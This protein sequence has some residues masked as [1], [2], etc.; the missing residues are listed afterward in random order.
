MR[1][2]TRKGLITMAATGGLLALSGGTALADSGAQGSSGHSPGVIS[3]NTF[4]APVNVTVNIC[5]NT[6]SVLGLLNPASGNGCSTGAPAGGSGAQHDRPGQHGGQTGHSPQGGR[7]DQATGG[8][9][10]GS[11]AHADGSSHGSPGV[12]SGNDVQVPVD[13]P[14]NVC[15]NSVDVVGVLNPAHG[16]DCGNPS[17]PAP[18]KPGKP[19]EP[20]KPGNPGEPEKPGNPG[21]PEKPGNPGEPEKPG[22]PG[23]PEKPGNPE[24][25]GNPGKPEKPGSPE[26]PD[27]PGE[28]G[29]PGTPDRPDGST[30][31]RTASHTEAAPADTDPAGTGEL[32]H[33][34]SASQL[35]VAVPVSVGMLAGGYVL[36][37]RSRV[38]ARR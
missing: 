16:N 23:E 20:E 34:G 15:G 21:E 33:T 3:G 36:Y 32:A 30:E 31:V 9:H 10:G 26:V 27:K 17:A 28:P 6:V 11:G 25:P 13:V 29:E 19:G 24:N 1:Q 12:V 22:N 8:G 5:G 35:G 14:V 2:G 37:R 4:Q 18:E 7:G 38:A